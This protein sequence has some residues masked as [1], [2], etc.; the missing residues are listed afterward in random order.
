MR[1]HPPFVLSCVRRFSPGSRRLDGSEE[2]EGE[3]DDEDEDF[4][5]LGEEEDVRR[6]QDLEDEHPF[7]LSAAP[8]RGQGNCRD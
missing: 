8:R 3:Q 5:E 7:W 4:D 6:V 2:Q 1:I